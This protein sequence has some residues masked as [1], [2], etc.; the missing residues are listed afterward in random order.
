MDDELKTLRVPGNV[1]EAITRLSELL[2][3]RGVSVLASIDHAAG[4]RA[5]GLHLADEVVVLFGNPAVGTG[6]MQDDPR[7]G[8]D[9]PLRMLLWDDN[10]TTYAGYRDPQALSDLFDLADHRDV[11][12]K[13]SEFMTQL[14]FDLSVEH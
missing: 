7:A 9:L 10:G 4:A 12:A 14:A 8:I 5:A 3:R 1:V 13:L 11:P 6:L 2:R